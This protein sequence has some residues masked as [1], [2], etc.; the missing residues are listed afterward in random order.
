[1]NA[2]DLKPM[3]QVWI[4]CNNYV[5]A[6]TVKDVC[7]GDGR[8]YVADRD[9]N[10]CYVRWDRRNGAWVKHDKLFATERD[11][12]IELSRQLRE[13]AAH[14]IRVADQLDC[15]TNDCP[16]AHLCR[17]GVEGGGL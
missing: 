11:A 12:K 14:L 17:H 7:T 10:D 16:D 9:G 4:V 8:P 13:Q 5:V 15:E 2:A 1:M 3:Q 6:K